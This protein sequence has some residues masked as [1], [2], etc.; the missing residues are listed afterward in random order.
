MDF[1]RFNIPNLHVS[2]PHYCLII[3]NWG[4]LYYDVR[5]IFVLGM[6][7]SPFYLFVFSCLD[8]ISLNLHFLNHF[9]CL[10]IQIRPKVF[11]IFLETSKSNKIVGCDSSQQRERHTPDIAPPDDEPWLLA[12]L[13]TYPGRL[14]AV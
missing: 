3:K 9:F 13:P 2:D 11:A 12:R 1:R 5:R 6:I 14:S 7:L 8:L 10:F 4:P